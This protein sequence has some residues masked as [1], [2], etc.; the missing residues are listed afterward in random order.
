MVMMI[1]KVKQAVED[2]F[3]DPWVKVETYNEYELIEEMEHAYGYNIVEVTEYIHEDTGE[4]KETRWKVI[5]DRVAKQGLDPEFEQKL[6]N[7][8]VDEA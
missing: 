1:S 6:L 3:Y 5:S 4:T 8:G 2:I 7:G